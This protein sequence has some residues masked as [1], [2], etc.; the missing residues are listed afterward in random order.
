MTPI[1]LFFVDSLI[2][3]ANPKCPTMTIRSN[4]KGIKTDDRFAV[5]CNEQFIGI[6]RRTTEEIIFGR[7]EFVFN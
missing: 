5:F 4:T 6:Y 2:K 1:P 3:K 7:S